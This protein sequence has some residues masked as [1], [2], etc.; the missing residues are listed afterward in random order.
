[1]ARL[2]T[3]SDRQLR[4]IGIVRSQIEWAV[5]GDIERGRSF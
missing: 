2:H 1:M 4:D 5:R 3:M